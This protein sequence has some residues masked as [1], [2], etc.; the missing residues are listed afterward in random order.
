MPTPYTPAHFDANP[1][2]LARELLGARLERTLPD[3]RVLA[4]RVV[5][6]EAYDCP[7]DPSCT[8]GRFHHIKTLELAAPPGQFVFW[9]AYGHPL[10]QIACRAEGT[11]ASVLIRALEPLEGVDAMLEHRPV[12]SERNLTSGPAKLVQALALSPATF[13]GQSV[14][15]AAL[16]LLHG[17]AV[18]DER[19]S[20]TARVGIAAGRNL[21][22]RFFET[23]SKWISGGVPSMEL[24]PG[25]RGL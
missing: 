8:A 25:E 17:E 5:E 12:A 22:W 14:N 15:G 16:R 2:T 19:V 10:L 20:I 7:R 18:P 24:A 3:G 6:A 4:G 9:V 11:A 21:P 1:V 23:G 13:R